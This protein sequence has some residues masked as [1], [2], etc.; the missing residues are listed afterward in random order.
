MYAPLG[1]TKS[2]AAC[3][4][5]TDKDFRLGGLLAFSQFLFVK[6]SLDIPQQSYRNEIFLYLR[7]L[8]MPSSILIAD[9]SLVALG[10]DPITA[11]TIALLGDATPC[12]FGGAG[13]TTISGGA[14]LVD[15][16]VSTTALNAAMAGRFHMFGILIIPF[17][18]IMIAFNDVWKLIH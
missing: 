2:V 7:Y 10:F 4:T 11:I 1:K 8:I 17:L 14:A 6:N 18:M 13:L 5:V 12:S 15:A 9:P 16:G 3:S